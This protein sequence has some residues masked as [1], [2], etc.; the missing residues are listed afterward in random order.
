MVGRQ[1]LAHLRTDTYRNGRKVDVS[2]FFAIGCASVHPQCCREF[3]CVMEHDGRDVSIEGSYDDVVGVSNII[4]GFGGGR[5]RCLLRR[6]CNTVRQW[7]HASLYQLQRRSV[8]IRQ[9]GQHTRTW[10][11]CMICAYACS[12]HSFSRNVGNSVLNDGGLS[13]SLK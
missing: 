9:D 5:C 12:F 2:S 3:P 8:D 10:R 6:G 1:G 13:A 4:Y 7:S 11:S